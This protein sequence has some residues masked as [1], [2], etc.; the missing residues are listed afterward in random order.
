MYFGA[1]SVTVENVLTIDLID[2]TR[3]L[4]VL[5]DEVGEVEMEEA[6]GKRTLRRKRAYRL[7]KLSQTNSRKRSRSLAR[8]SVSP[9]Q[10]Q[11]DRWKGSIFLLLP[12]SF[13]TTPLRR[14]VGIGNIARVVCFFAATHIP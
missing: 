14:H 11:L 1:L 8:V 6:G 9:R 7:A 12:W 5:D 13:L 4:D 2:Q 10:D 3:W